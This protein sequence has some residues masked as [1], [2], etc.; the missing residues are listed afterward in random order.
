MEVN[1]EYYI[2][3]AS[4]LNFLRSMPNVVIDCLNLGVRSGSGNVSTKG[5][6][7]DLFCCFLSGCGYKADF[8]GTLCWR[9]GPSNAGFVWLSVRQAVRIGAVNGQKRPIYT[10]SHLVLESV[11]SRLEHGDFE[12]KFCVTWLY[13]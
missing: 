1:M 4:S 8:L 13:S 7:F 12:N 3:S 5:P 11:I 9:C 6:F 10:P 2:L